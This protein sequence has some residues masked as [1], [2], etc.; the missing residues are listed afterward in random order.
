MQSLFIF[1]DNGQIVNHETARA[2]FIRQ[3]AVCRMRWRLKSWDLLIF[4]CKPL[5]FYDNHCR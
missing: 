3:T 2:L 1:N 5:P 4:L